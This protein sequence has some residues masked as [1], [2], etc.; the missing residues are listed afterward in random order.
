MHDGRTLGV[1]RPS[2]RVV[3]KHDDARFDESAHP[4]G[5]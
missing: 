3:E 4:G 2:S 5:S 1:D